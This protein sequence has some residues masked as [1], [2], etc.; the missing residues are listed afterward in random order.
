MI[1]PLFERVKAIITARNPASGKEKTLQLL[2][3]LKKK[4]QQS[5][6]IRKE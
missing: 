6:L 4:N 2:P 1:E 3:L 5:I